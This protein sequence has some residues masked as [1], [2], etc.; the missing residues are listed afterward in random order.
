MR[1]S[2]PSTSV[3]VFGSMPRMPATNTKSP[4]RVPTLQVPVGAMAP[5]GA[6]VFT[7]FGEEL[8]R[9]NYT[10]DDGAGAAWI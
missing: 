2:S 1:A 7:P 8:M 5:A 9:Q 3:F 6:S 4:A 10:R